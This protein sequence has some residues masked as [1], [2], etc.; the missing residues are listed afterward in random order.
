M[1]TGG[2]FDRWDIEVRG[3]MFGA[4]RCRMTVEEHGEGRQLIRM[5]MWP[6]AWRGGL[7]LVSGL[8]F[9]A[10][11]AM[12]S[13]AAVVGVVLGAPAVAIVGLCLRDCA[14]AT[15]ALLDGFREQSLVD[16][17]QE[18]PATDGQPKQPAADARVY[19]RP[20]IA[21]ES[22]LTLASRR[23]AS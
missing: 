15:G 18:Q 17:R 16:A 6:R 7:A 14:H 9:L 3:G 4:A 23:K 2:A 13:G 19:R 21:S 12:L 10:A 11:G 8:A 1:L 5:R 20:V 22:V